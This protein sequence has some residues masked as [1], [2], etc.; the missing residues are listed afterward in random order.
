MTADPRVSLF[1][2]LPAQLGEGILW[3][4]VRQSLLWIDILGKAFF[5][6]QLENN[7]TRRMPLGEFIGALVPTADGGLLA[8]LHRGVFRLDPESGAATPLALPADHDPAKLR[9]NDAK[10]DPQG[11]L[12]GGT[13]AFADTPGTAKL[14]RF[15][16]DRSVH[17]MRTGVTVSNGLAWSADGRTLYYIDSPTRCVQAFDFD[18]ETGALSRPRVALDLSGTPGFPDGCT[19]DTEDRLWVA[20]WD[21]ARVTCWDPVKGKLIDTLHVPVA[22]P[23]SC[24][25]GGPRLD[26]L[27]ICSAEDATSAATPAG[28]PRGGHVFCAQPGAQGRPAVCCELS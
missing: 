1:R 17:I 21:G 19:I 8:T 10:C 24:T 16:R 25:F 9:F 22:R 23:S 6:T 14:Y 27:F 28:V 2:A 26:T 20:H 11:R 5:E 4:P 13:I 15:D 3:H 7:N 18:G 12:W